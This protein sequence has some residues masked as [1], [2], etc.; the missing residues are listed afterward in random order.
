LCKVNN[1][2]AAFVAQLLTAQMKKL[3]QQIL[4]TLTCDREQPFSAHKSF[5]I[6]TDKAV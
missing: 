4:K 2:N 5:I 3:P 1:K 6:A